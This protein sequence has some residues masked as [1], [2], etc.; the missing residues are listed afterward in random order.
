MKPPGKFTPI[1][2]LTIYVEIGLAKAPTLCNIYLF[3]EGFIESTDNK[4][5]AVTGNLLTYGKK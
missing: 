5:N 4:T 3:K 2:Y 1:E